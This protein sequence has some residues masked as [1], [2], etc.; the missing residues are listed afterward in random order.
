MNWQRWSLATAFVCLVACGDNKAALISNNVSNTNNTNPNNTVNN[1]SNNTTNNG[2]TSNNTTNNG[3]N[4]NTNNPTNNVV[5]D[6]YDTVPAEDLRDYDGT[7]PAKPVSDPVEIFVY[8]MVEAFCEKVVTCRT[9]YFV[10]SKIIQ[11]G[12]GTKG[13][14]MQNFFN[15]NPIAGYSASVADG[16]SQFFPD[17]IAFC[18]KVVTC[19]TDYFVASKV[20]QSGVGTKGDCMQSFFNRNPIAGYSAAVADGRSQF[21]PD[22]IPFCDLAI[23]NAQCGEISAA[24]VSP[25]LVFQA[26]EDVLTGLSGLDNECFS[27]ADCA[28]GT[29]CSLG[30]G[31]TCGGVCSELPALDVYCGVGGDVKCEYTEYCDLTDFQCKTYVASGGACTDSS[32]CITGNWC[33]DEVCA[34]IKF[35][36]QLGQPCNYFSNLCSMGL[37]CDADFENGTCA[38]IATAGEACRAV[39]D[40]SYDTRCDGMNCVQKTDEG[41]CT[42][43][44]DCLS[45]A[46]QNDGVCMSPT[47]ACV[48]PAE[49]M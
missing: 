9:D 28:A 29:Y 3:T 26:C 13:D 31:N 7:I 41:A 23:G 1:G 37:Y 19:R 35:G 47:A 15:R 5:E 43:S 36:Y 38:E 10:A 17:E 32:Q 46:C 27:N 34:P 25:R 6:I 40:C 4:N 39:S 21:F 16:R 20:I 22:E 11:S 42:F 45:A 2:T 49:M 14:C 48:P 33:H 18:E 12:V 24:F 44:D 8:D 30:L